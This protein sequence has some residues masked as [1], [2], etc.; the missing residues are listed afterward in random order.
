MNPEELRKILEKVKS[1]RLSVG[2]VVKRLRT[3]PYEDI[4]FAKVDLHRSLRK[5]F[6]EAI[7]CEGKS[8]EQV[9]R[10]VDKLVGFKEDV[11]ATRASEE[12]Y[13]EVKRKHRKA[14]YHKEAR[15]IVIS[16]RRRERKGLILIT[17][18]GTSDIPVAEEA[19]VT[20]E[21]MGNRVEKLYDV[22][23][24]GVHRIL[25]KREKLFKANCIIVVA[26]MEG[27]LSSVVGGIT[28]RPVIAVPTSIGYGASFEGIAPLLTML[29]TCAPGVAVVNIDNGFG[30]GYMASLINQ[31]KVN[32]AETY[33]T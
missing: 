22:G 17:C 7:F 21:V 31:G 33:G 19:V 8:K 23:V 9:V 28:D 3:L 10:I 27:A 6:P 25:D 30:A 11:L 26:G 32:E 18:A 5:G 1:G 29:N 4:G 15:A 14:V 24:A 2:Q 12:I 16:Q 13:R 20:A